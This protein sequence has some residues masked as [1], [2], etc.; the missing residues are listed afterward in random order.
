ML[1]VDPFYANADAVK[2]YPLTY[3][4]AGM[5]LVPYLSPTTVSF[6]R[7]ECLEIGEDATDITRYFVN[8]PAEMLGHHAAQGAD[9]WFGI[10]DDNSWK[11][12][13]DAGTPPEGLAP[14]SPGGWLGGGTFSWVIPGKWRIK[15]DS[16][17]EHTGIHFSDQQFS[18]DA[19][20]TMTVTKFSHKA[21]R[22]VTV[23]NSTVTPWP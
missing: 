16:T 12:G 3:A 2:S 9:Q 7:L 6:Y 11:G 14:W 20:G 22:P 15:G 8:M 1:W 5:H 23:E 17:T 13:D 4:G 10:N 18:M 19:F 21:T